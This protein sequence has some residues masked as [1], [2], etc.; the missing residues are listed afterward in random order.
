MIEKIAGLFHTKIIVN[1]GGQILYGVAGV[2]KQETIQVI[3]LALKDKLQPQF[4]HRAN[5]RLQMRISARYF[6]GR[7]PYLYRHHIHGPQNL[8]GILGRKNTEYMPAHFFLFNKIF[9]TRHEIS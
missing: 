7:V 3:T 6:Q 1:Y 8:P 5:V 9:F 4:D 2:R